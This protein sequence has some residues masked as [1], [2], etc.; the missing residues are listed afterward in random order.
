MRKYKKGDLVK[1]LIDEFD[2]A[3]GGVY[4]VKHIDEDC[5]GV[6]IEDD[7]GDEHYMLLNEIERANKF[8][9]GDRVRA[10]GDEPNGHC[11][12]IVEIDDDSL[13]YLV[14]FDDW[15][16]GHGK[17]DCEFWM[18]D[19]N[20]EAAP[21]FKVGDRV[22]VVKTGE[23]GSLHGAAVGEQFTVRY[24]AREF[25]DT[26]MWS[27]D[28]D[29]I[30]PVAVAATTPTI[31]AGSY[32]RTRDGR[33]AGPMED[34][35]RDIEGVV[36]GKVRCYSKS[37]EHLFGDDSLELVGEWKIEAGRYYKTRD[38]RKVGPMAQYGDYWNAE[39]GANGTPGHFTNEGFSAWCG[40]LPREDW[41]EEHDLIA[42]WSGAPVATASAATSAATARGCAA[43]EVDNQRGEY[44]WAVGEP[45]FKMGD[46]VEVTNPALLRLGTPIGATG[47][48]TAAGENY[49]EF[50]LDHPECGTINQMLSDPE[51][52]LRLVAPAT[53]GKFKVGDIVRVIRHE[54]NMGDAIHKNIPIGAVRS[55]VNITDQIP[56]VQ[57]CS[58]SGDNTYFYTPKDLELVSSPATTQQ[59]AIVA[60]IENGQPKPSP[61]PY[62]HDSRR[63]AEAEAARLAI[64]HKG[65]EF[66]VYELVTTRREAKLYAHEWQR[67]ALEHKKIGAIQELRRITGMSLKP[68]KD[69]VEHFLAA[70]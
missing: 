55:I 1:S 42:E 50:N 53:S 8:K 49:T 58:L 41:R 61:S 15:T 37:G 31:E 35:G 63:N 24:I 66:G 45:K 47:V 18:Q 32:Y 27:F 68:A 26:D 12:V 52:H 2:V 3:K 19:R 46:R 59:S 4:E 51:K 10:T 7:V 39:A 20:L 65:K 28:F 9:V 48:I 16:D 30:E 36:D 23:D 40:R 11:G 67:L 34:T 21:A 57:C 54:N 17:G 13:P 69:A 29:E 6:W 70:A 60:L 33:R 22:R 5:D 56:G 25:I 14:R 38:G 62:V 43:A 44:G 64:K